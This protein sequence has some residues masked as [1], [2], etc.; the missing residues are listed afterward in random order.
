MSFQLITDIRRT[1]LSIKENPKNADAR[2]NEVNN[3][4]IYCFPFSF[5]PE[6]LTPS[7]SGVKKKDGNKYSMK[8]QANWVKPLAVWD[9]AT[10]EE[11]VELF[12][13]F[14]KPGED[15][16]KQIL[17]ESLTKHMPTKEAAKHIKTLLEPLGAWRTEFNIKKR[18]HDKSEEK[19]KE[20]IKHRKQN[21]IHFRTIEA[22]FNG[23]LEY[24]KELLQKTD[25][26][27]DEDM[28]LMFWTW[29]GVHFFS[30][31]MLRGDVKTLLICPPKENERHPF[32]DS[33]VIYVSKTN[34]TDHTAIIKPR[35]DV[36]ELLDGLVKIQK[37]Y[38]RRHMFYYDNMDTMRDIVVTPKLR[39][40][41]NK[42][43]DCHTQRSIKNTY[44]HQ[45]WGKEGGDLGKQAS[46]IAEPFDH[47]MET[48]LQDYVFE[49]LYDPEWM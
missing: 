29:L 47:L 31:L 10:D 49:E 33:G 23:K 38:K 13:Y 45:K 21:W 43:P 24:L 26:T 32:Y 8:T 4:L 25:R 5:E 39:Q 36:R 16:N 19:R 9:K 3:A 40:Y 18:E 22:A 17:Y 35:E 37:H 42:S 44:M 1:H 28:E 20:Q 6:M 2:K 46:Y 41:F 11:L 14:Y 12:G 34:K 7:L 27:H 48:A 30:D 15:V